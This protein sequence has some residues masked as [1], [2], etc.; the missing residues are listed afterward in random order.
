MDPWETLCEAGLPLGAVRPPPIAFD[1]EKVAQALGRLSATEVEAARRDVL[2]AWLSAWEHHWPA[3]FSD[4]GGALLRELRS[5]PLD[6]N[7]YLKLR[8]V[9]IANLAGVL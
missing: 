5:Q 7:R 2:A 1:R 6:E 9:A 3:S 4:E 8:R